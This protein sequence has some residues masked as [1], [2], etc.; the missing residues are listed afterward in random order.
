MSRR[1]FFKRASDLNTE[2]LINILGDIDNGS[3]DNKLEEKNWYYKMDIFREEIIE[4]LLRRYRS[5][6]SLTSNKDE[7]LDKAYNIYLKHYITI[8]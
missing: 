5:H 2:N 8:L 1:Y 7:F 3:F 6:Y 4:I